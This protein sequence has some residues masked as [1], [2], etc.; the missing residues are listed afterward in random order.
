MEQSTRRTLIH[1]RDATHVPFNYMIAKFPISV[2]D[3]K[4]DV[5]KGRHLERTFF[6]ATIQ[7]KMASKAFFYKTISRYEVQL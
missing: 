2:G 3:K 4:I 1:D 7:N 5:V 6:N